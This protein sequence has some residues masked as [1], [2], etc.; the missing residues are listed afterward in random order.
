MASVREA[1]RGCA[2]PEDDLSA[3]SPGIFIVWEL[4]QEARNM[5]G[6]RGG[7]TER[8]A[9]QTEFLGRLMFDFNREI[10]H[11]LR[12]ELG[13]RQLINAGNWRTADQ[14]ILDDVER[15]TYGANDVIGKN[16]YFAAMHNGINAGWQF[17]PGQTFTSKSFATDPEQ[18]S[19]QC[20]Q[21]VG[22][23]FIISEGLW[24]PPNR[25]E[26]E[27][28]LIVAAQS[29]LTGLDAFLWFATNVEEWQ[30]P[31]MKWTFSVP[32]TLGQF[33]AAALIFRRSYVRKGPVVVH[34]ERRLHDIWDREL[35]L[36]AESGA[37]DP[38]R[39]VGRLPEGM[40]FKTGADP[41]AYL[42]GRVEV[43]YDGNPSK[44]TVIDLA[45]YIDPAK[46][47][48]RSVTGEIE[49]DLARGLYR[50]DTPRAQAV[51]GMLGKSGMQKL[52]DVT[53]L[54]KNN[55]AC[56]TVVAT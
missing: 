32:M 43:L 15:W 33:P 39:D 20:A 5:K 25:Y 50:V 30:P 11:Y 49:T 44:S 6:D 27:G 16:H 19:P 51:A 45:S 56:V 53:I 28:P 13:C 8:M 7:R 22:H 14:I 36:I 4:T 21:V 55:Y 29:S 46:K 26:A 1:W 47:R 9:D 35:P 41:L 23:P 48:V 12:K 2:H 10:A 31:G 18:F 3:G 42:V 40:P 54:S 37:W 17:L 34:E 24:V 38:N 52:S